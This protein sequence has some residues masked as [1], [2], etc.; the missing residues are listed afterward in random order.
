VIVQLRQ[1]DAPQLD[2]WWQ[3]T[4]GDATHFEGDLFN[5]GRLHP[6]WWHPFP[7]AIE[8]CLINFFVGF[9]LNEPASRP[10][11]AI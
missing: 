10:G 8:S 1:I 2:W 4:H 6:L 11:N 9:P 3:A 5:K 7:N